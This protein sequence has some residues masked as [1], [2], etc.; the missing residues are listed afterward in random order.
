M[1]VAEAFAAGLPI[2]A[3]R[4]GA[5]A[6]LVEDGTTGLHFS[7]NDPLDL[8]A[9]VQW[10]TANPERMREMGVNARATYERRYTPEIN[11]ERLM[12]IYGEALALKTA[13]HN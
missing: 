9:K 3:S 12:A 6:E 4:L 1:V 8:A 5:L 13:K 11:F 7:A 2:I 10:A